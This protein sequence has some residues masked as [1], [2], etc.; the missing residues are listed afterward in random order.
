VGIVGAA[1][2][3]DSPVAAERAGVVVRGAETIWA[4]GRD[5]ETGTWPATEPATAPELALLP[6]E[7]AD[8]PASR[9]DEGWAA[10]GGAAEATGRAVGF[11]VGA[12]GDTEAAAGAVEITA[13]RNSFADGD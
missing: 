2:A 5:D 8:A 13:P 3:D 11:T 10:A 9:L 7:P 6:V 12:E 4:T 1:G